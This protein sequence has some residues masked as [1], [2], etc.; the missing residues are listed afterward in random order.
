M[1]HLNENE[2]PCGVYYPI[3][4]HRQKA[5]ADSR[6]E[7]SNFQ[8]TN[9]LVDEV[10]SLPMHTELDQDQIDFITTTVKSFVNG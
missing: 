9:R 4:L 2:I 7:E 5:Y 1:K 3:P 8:V 6:Y 10:V